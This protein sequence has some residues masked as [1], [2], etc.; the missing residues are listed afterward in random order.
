MGY[1]RNLSEILIQQ[2]I[3]SCS[4]WILIHLNLN[5]FSSEVADIFTNAYLLESGSSISLDSVSWDY[6]C[7]YASSFYIGCSYFGISHSINQFLDLQLVILHRF[8]KVLDN[9]VYEIIHDDKVTVKVFLI[10]LLISDFSCLSFCF[11]LWCYSKRSYLSLGTL[12]ITQYQ[13]QKLL[14][15]GLL[16]II[17]ISILRTLC[18]RI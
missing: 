18:G 4:R 3:R 16:Q 7:S 10:L 12:R 11:S 2:P 5:Q 13:N 17:S 1:H 6:F 8:L 15:C 14:C 9:C